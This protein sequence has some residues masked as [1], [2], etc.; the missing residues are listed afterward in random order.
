MSTAVNGRPH[1]GQV[2]AVVILLVSITSVFVISHL[3]GETSGMSGH[4]AGF[5]CTGDQPG[6]FALVQREAGTVKGSQLHRFQIKIHIDS[7]A[8]R[9]ETTSTSASWLRQIPSRS[10]NES[11]RDTWQPTRPR[12]SSMAARSVHL[13]DHK[14]TRASFIDFMARTSRPI[15]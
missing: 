14:A 8:L 3:R 6:K 1:I 15:N 9:Q 13:R 4:L 7:R 10:A 2:H 12:L 11:T 5:H